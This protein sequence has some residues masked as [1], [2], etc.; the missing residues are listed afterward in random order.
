MFTTLVEKSLAIHVCCV[1]RDLL[2]SSS[3]LSSFEVK[4]N[5]LP[6]FKTELPKGLIELLGTGMANVGCLLDAWLG[7]L[8]QRHDPNVTVVE[9]DGHVLLIGI[10]KV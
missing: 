3:K 8:V 7:Y 5:F 1:S 4:R 9:S 10:V 2:P 6:P